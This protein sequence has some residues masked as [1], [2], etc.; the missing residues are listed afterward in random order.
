MRII[1][2]P[3]SVDSTTV[4]CEFC[5]CVY[6][7]EHDDLVVSVTDKIEVFC[8]YCGRVHVVGTR[9]KYTHSKTTTTIL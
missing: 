6:E 7:F 8:P 4:K 1:E 2:W 9:R 5:G 3:S